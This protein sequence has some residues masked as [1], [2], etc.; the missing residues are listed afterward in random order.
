VQGLRARDGFEVDINWDKGQLTRAVIHST[1]GK[2]CKVGYKDKVVS[3]DINQGASVILDTDLT[4][5]R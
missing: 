3:L 2:S 5:P 4:T 1:W